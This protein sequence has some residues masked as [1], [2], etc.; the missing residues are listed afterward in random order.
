M[1]TFS[2]IAVQNSL[3][4]GSPK[5][6]L[7]DIPRLACSRCPVYAQRT[8]R[9]FRPLIRIGRIG[10]ISPAHKNWY[11]LSGT[12]TLVTIVF[13]AWICRRAAGTTS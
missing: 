12:M 10:T 3:V 1:P 9:L 4:S 6:F 5:P 2:T 8:V 7:S 13:K 11:K